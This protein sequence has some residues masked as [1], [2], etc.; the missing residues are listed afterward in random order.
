MIAFYT[1]GYVAGRL[2][3]FDGGRQGF[4]VWMIALVVALLAGGGGWVLVSSPTGA[5]IVAVLPTLP[6]L[7]M[8]PASPGYC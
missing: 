8:L 5:L 2:A 6:T 1:G 7:P 4:G 3:R